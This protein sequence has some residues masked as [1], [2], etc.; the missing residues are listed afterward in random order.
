MPHIVWIDG[1]GG[2]VTYFNRKWTEYTGLDLAET[3]RVGAD[4]LVH[5]DDLDEVRRVFGEARRQGAAFTAIYRL[6]RARDGVYRWH[7]AHVV[8]LH[9]ED[10]RAE[11]FVGTAVDIDDQRRANH[12]Q[13][14]LAEAGKVLGTSLETTRTLNDVARL[15]VPE[16]ADWCA[17][18]LLNE[19]GIFE[20]LAVAHVDPTKVALARDLWRRRPPRPE[21]PSGL[22]AVA[23]TR[24]AEFFED[25]P[26]EM[27]VA[28]IP[29]PELLA[30]YRSLG[31][32]SSMCVPLIA[33][34][35]VL[36]AL[37]LVTAESGR[38]YGREDL[39]FAYDLAGR[40]AVAIDNARLYTAAQQ[41]RA[42]A[43]AL[44]ADVADQS[45]NVEAA[46]LAMRAE[47]DA[48]LARLA[49]LER[50]AGRPQGQ[51]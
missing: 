35:R 12:Q 40:I 31:L 5:P 1:P 2:A 20:R 36:G 8:P 6:R 38:H 39:D 11:S 22:Y 19:A 4:T 25:I 17:I 32:R 34:D 29:D 14:F 42:A 26:D 13:R 43:E 37:S 41:A 16:L 15:V 45:R 51:S 27:L 3:L 18:D 21:D 44:A 30:L 48:A 50:A 7:E 9:S 33:R 23:R 47:R 10:G 49:Q 24:Q 46:L 28:S